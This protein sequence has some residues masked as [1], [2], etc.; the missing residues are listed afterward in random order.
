[1]KTKDIVITIMGL[2]IT[3]II[4][5]STMV[6]FFGLTHPIIELL[7]LDN[8]YILVL[9]AVLVTPPI[10]I[11]F[12]YVFIIGRN[13]R[14][15]LQRSLMFGCLYYSLALIA[16]WGLSSILAV[17][18]VWP[19]AW[20]IYIIANFPTAVTLNSIDIQRHALNPIFLLTAITPGLFFYLGGYLRIRS[21]KAKELIKS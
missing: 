7:Q 2:V 18:E 14:E 13:Q 11:I 1:M 6:F 12:G 8:L 4:L 21:L 15:N 9:V 3:Q 17:M 16:I 5:M 20:E 19:N 10:Y